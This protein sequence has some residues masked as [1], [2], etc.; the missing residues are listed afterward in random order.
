L[1]LRASLWFRK[2]GSFRLI[3]CYLPPPTLPLHSFFSSLFS[4]DVRFLP[5][6]F[7]TAFDHCFRRSLDTC[8]NCTR[9]PYPPGRFFSVFC[10]ARHNQISGPSFFPTFSSCFIFFRVW[11]S[12]PL[13]FRGFVVL[14]PRHIHSPCALILL[15]LWLPGSHTSTNVRI[16]WLLNLISFFSP[17]PL[18]LFYL[19]GVLFLFLVVPAFNDFSRTFSPETIYTYLASFLVHKVRCPFFVS[20]L[21]GSTLQVPV[22]SP[23]H[24]FPDTH[25]PSFLHPFPL[26]RIVPALLPIPF[27]PSP[28][29]LVSRL[30]VKGSPLDGFYSFPFFVVDRAPNPWP[31]PVAPS[32][33]TFSP[34]FPTL[35]SKTPLT[36]IPLALRSPFF[37]W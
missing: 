26:R 32:Q 14:P 30:S 27:S 7:R 8:Q 15:S 6:T 19:Y 3:R 16:Q 28:Y 2:L 13:S 9:P 20:Q 23:S 18:I 17:P 25:P 12:H 36:F 29:P 33:P 10:R 11:D 31:V 1:P 22:I 5:N 24:H 34:S 37:L 21:Y 35:F 4:F